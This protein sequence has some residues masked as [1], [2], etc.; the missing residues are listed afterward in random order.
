MRGVLVVVA[1][2]LAI[3]VVVGVVVYLRS[4]LV[5]Q[6]FPPGRQRTIAGA[7]LAGADGSGPVGG[8]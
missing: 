6:P 3:A 8:G 5:R 2:L 4:R 1:V 7:V